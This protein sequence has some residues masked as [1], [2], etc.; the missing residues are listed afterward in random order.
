MNK[1]SLRG[2]R[3]LEAGKSY[4]S[5]LRQHVVR[6]AFHSDDRVLTVAELVPLCYPSA[7][8]GKRWCRKSIN[9]ALPKFCER[10]GRDL[11]KRGRPQR[12]RLKPEFRGVTHSEVLRRLRGEVF[13][14]VRDRVK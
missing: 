2:G 13:V 6:R 4:R 8:Q 10:V 7:D 11:T 5:G 1:R 12:W 9:R 14:P 3:L